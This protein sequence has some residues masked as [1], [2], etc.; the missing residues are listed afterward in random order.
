SAPAEPTVQPPQWRARRRESHRRSGK[1]PRT[2]LPPPLQADRPPDDA[3][4]R[5]LRCPK[6]GRAKRSLPKLCGLG[7]FVRRGRSSKRHE[8][9]RIHGDELS[10]QPKRFSIHSEDFRCQTQ[11]LAQRK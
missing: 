7:E 6:R 11:I 5:T 9:T 10:A 1:A 8:A 2:R 3:R 4:Y